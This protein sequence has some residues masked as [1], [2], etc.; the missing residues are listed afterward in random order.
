MHGEHLCI[1]KPGN[2]RPVMARL[3]EDDA[4]REKQ[5]DADHGDD[6]IRL[7]DVPDHLVRVDQIVYGDEVVPHPEL[8][9]EDVFPCGDAQKQ[10][11]VHPP[12]EVEGNPPPG[13]PCLRDEKADGEAEQ[14]PAQEDAGY[15]GR[16]AAIL[17]E[18]GM[19][20]QHVDE[21]RGQQHFYHPSHDTV[22]FPLVQSE[23]ED[24]QRQGE[25]DG[26]AEVGKQADAQQPDRL[27]DGERG[28]TGCSVHQDDPQE[29]SCEHIQFQKAGLDEE[30][31]VSV[32]QFV[33][34]HRHLFSAKL[35]KIRG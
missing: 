19:E 13:L 32:D 3:E 16:T 4:C 31:R 11:D 9:P 2:L 20:A 12:G 18:D 23:V 22:V 25:Q 34:V 17:V 30:Y 27:S 33:L 7:H 5:R 10:E 14:L 35:H 6:G 24:L 29:K 26:H 8:S 1:V 21:G 15:L 28:I